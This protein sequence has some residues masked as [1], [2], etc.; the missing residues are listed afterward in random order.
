MIVSTTTL[1]ASVP[2]TGTFERTI[3]NDAGARPAII[4]TSHVRSPEVVSV[5]ATVASNLALVITIPLA[6]V[7]R[8][9]S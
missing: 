1:F 2:P 5:H 3:L 9:I 6:L 4:G 7:A 8:V